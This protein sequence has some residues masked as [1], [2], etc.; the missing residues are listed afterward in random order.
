MRTK[1]R[2]EMVKS[3]STV[4]QDLFFLLLARQANQ[5]PSTGVTSSWIWMAIILLVLRRSSCLVYYFPFDSGASF[6]E[7][8]SSL[9]N[10]LGET[11]SLPSSRVSPSVVLNDR[12]DGARRVETGVFCRL[13]LCLRPSS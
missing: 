12:C 10:G 9:G 5:Q 1:E 13:W 7:L 3:E 11:G 4:G 2:D 8:R 6:S